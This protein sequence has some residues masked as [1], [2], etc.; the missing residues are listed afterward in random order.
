MKSLPKS[1]VP[2]SN[3]NCAPLSLSDKSTILYIAGNSIRE[4]HPYIQDVLHDD[5]ETPVIQLSEVCKLYKSRLHQLDEIAQSNFHST[6]FKN[7]IL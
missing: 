1:L 4:L 7:E 5:E 6:R 3:R 2:L